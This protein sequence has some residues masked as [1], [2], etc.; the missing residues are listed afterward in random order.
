MMNLGLHVIQNPVGTFSY[1]G[2]IPMAL[3][4]MRPA[5]DY[6]VMAMRAVRNPMTGELVAP[7]FPT[8]ATKAEAVA[9][10]AERGFAAR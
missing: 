1:V 7:K 3:A 8:F 10:A 9:F 6:D 5:T 4:T 2:S